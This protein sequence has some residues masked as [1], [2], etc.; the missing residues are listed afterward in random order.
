M[1]FFCFKFLN[2]VYNDFYNFID[3]CFFFFFFPPNP[4][5][6]TF[7]TRF[8]MS[9]T[10]GIFMYVC[11][12]VCIQVVLGSNNWGGFFDAKFS[13]FKFSFITW[14]GMC[15]CDGVAIVVKQTT[16]NSM[17]QN[18]NHFKVTISGGLDS[19]K[20][21]QGQFFAG[22]GGSTSKMTHV[23]AALPGMT[24]RWALLG[25]WTTD[26]VAIPAWPSPDSWAFYW[27]LKD[28]RHVF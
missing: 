7:F 23:S 25:L 13:R 10:T 15:F 19:R 21:H 8:S 2:V 4:S 27:Q 17:V 26:H 6:I 11:M 18:N 22:S 16:Q 14:L 28:Q 24:R 3:S 1:P 20:G 9:A 12:Y 5:L